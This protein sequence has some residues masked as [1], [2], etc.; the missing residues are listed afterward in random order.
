M[1][2]T[3]IILHGTWIK[4]ESDNS[5]FF[6][7]WGEQRLAETS[8]NKPRG[9]SAKISAH[10]YAVSSVILKDV[11]GEFSEFLLLDDFDP[12]IMEGESVLTLPAVGK[13]PLPS[14]KTPIEFE[15][16][17]S[18]SDF[19][20]SAI[21]L[22]PTDAIEFLSSIPYHTYDLP[23]EIGADVRFWSATAK[24]TLH[25]ISQQRFLP[26]LREEE[27]DFIAS[28]IP[29]LDDESDT[30]KINT[31]TRAM[32]DACRTAKSILIHTN[33]VQQ[34][35]P[36]SSPDSLILDFLNVSVDNWV[37]IY[38]EQNLLPKSLKSLKD[39]AVIRWLKALTEPTGR[40]QP[41]DLRDDLK[42]LRKLLAV[43]RG[44]EKGSIAPKANIRTCFRLEP[45]ED[46][47]SKWALRYFLQ[48]VDDPSLLIP[49]DVMWKERKATLRYLNREF[50]SPQEQMLAGLGVASRMFPPIEQSLRQA[51]PGMCLLEL[52][53]AYQF[54]NETSLLLQ[55]SGFGVLAPPWWT[56]KRSPIKAKISV[57]ST[58][59]EGSGIISLDSI[60][61]YDWQI[62]L[63]ND[64]I[65]PE[66]LERLASLKVPLVKMRGEWVLLRPEDIKSAMEFFKKHDESQEISLRDV[67]QLSLSETPALEGIQIE[68][69]ESPQW[70]DSLITD[71]KG[72]SMK[73]LKQ[74]KDMTGKLRPYQVSGLS[75]LA[76]M[77]QWGLGACLADDMGLGKCLS[78]D[79]LVSI[80][81]SILEAEKIWE[82]YAEKAIW[83]GEGFWVNPVKHLITNS[84]DEE[85]G[86]IIQASINSLYRQ[87]VHEKLRTIH[88]EDGSSVTITYLHKLLTNNGWTNKLKVGDYVCVPAKINW[89]GKEKNVF[90]CKIKRVE[91]IDY[92][93]WVYDFEVDKHHNFVAN[94]ILCHNTIQMIALLLH[95]KKLKKGNSV[96]NLLICPTSVVGNWQREI[97][98]FAPSLKA[99]LHHGGDR[100]SGNEFAKSAFEHDL[101]LTSYGL[102]RRD[103]DDLSA[104]DWTGVMLDEAQNIKNPSSKIAQVVRNLKSKYRFTLTGT[105][106]ENRLMELWSIME[107]LNPG[108]LGSQSRFNQRYVVPIERYNDE[109]STKELKSLVAPFIMRRLK[110]D[111]KIINDLPEKIE[112]KEYC[113]LTR[114]QVTLYEAV[115]KDMMEQIE[116]K[117]GIERRGLI[118]SIL[119]K[120]KQLCNHPALFLHDKSDMDGR[121]GKVQRLTEMLEEVLS[122]G[123]KSLIFTQ[124]TEMGEA[125][126]QYLSNKF[127]C[128]VLYLHGGVPQKK[129]DRMVSLFQENSNE[130]PIFIISI[131]AGGTGLNLTRA[132]H[133]FHFDRWWN[134]AVEDQA[135]DRAFRIG[136]TKNVQVRKFICTG[137]LEEQIDQLIEKKKSLAQSIIGAGENWITELS[138]DDLQKLVT[139]RRDEALSDDER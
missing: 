6:L 123:D 95:E 27:D 70:L 99:M 43:W 100:A 85:T 59:T 138:N 108:Y 124:F 15:G 117:S 133:V 24:F 112:M 28:W 82:R 9:R 48:A 86:Q 60:L 120:L 80:N 4:Q 83:D 63:G 91:E 42:D 69:I 128:D 81:G 19:K 72:G 102:A 137:T 130:S 18:L 35:I 16:E 62:A 75:W 96:P 26:T 107:F 7:V 53:E 41:K 74:P 104:I 115:V 97:A 122:E 47:S 125:L 110:T 5:G 2:E 44:E 37:R 98:K 50:E 77:R 17:I 58:K 30:E 116:E 113:N 45:P 13:I 52:N 118:L 73:Q 132:N 49:A 33:K 54:L 131:R 40:F 11:V 71:L 121:S 101:V 10:P 114:E 67:M 90:Y 25:L 88:L 119:M 87:R 94:N 78:A 139:L 129:R 3:F 135:T 68:A 57:S 134:P 14:R 46:D 65:T 55:Q 21:Y 12:V 89:D 56:Q 93:G 105:P 84:L 61:V 39:E 22:S 51:K 92:D 126:Q 29:V 136:Q 111:P 127:R 31:L 23:Y 109:R 20:V 76:F 36:E 1:D 66:E 106:V 8:V 64:A 32:P 38:A 103:A 34:D 79:S